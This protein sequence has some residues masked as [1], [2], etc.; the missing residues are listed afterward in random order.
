MKLVAIF[1]KSGAL[2]PRKSTYFR[3]GQLLTDVDYIC[4]E[5]AADVL[6]REVSNLVHPDHPGLHPVHPD[7]PR[8]R[9]HHR[10]AEGEVP[11]PPPGGGGGSFAR[12]GAPPAKARE[13][14]RA[15]TRTGRESLIRIT[16]P[17]PQM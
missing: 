1:N 2:M 11:P 10:E 15:T 3:P 9:R 4:T 16:F 17:Y 14:V 13:Q 8:V 7:H 6:W 12:A 5:F